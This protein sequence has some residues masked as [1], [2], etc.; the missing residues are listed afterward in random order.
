MF[1]VGK[2][3]PSLNLGEGGVGYFKHKHNINIGG[4]DGRQR[5]TRVFIGPC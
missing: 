2:K 3:G 4:T 5:V 1:E